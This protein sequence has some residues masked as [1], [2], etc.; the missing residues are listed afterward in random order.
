LESYSL[1]YSV[2]MTPHRLENHCE[3]VSL[4]HYKSQRKEFEVHLICLRLRDFRNYKKL[5][6]EL[7][8]GFHLLTG[9][10][11]QGKTNFLEAIYLLAS[12]KSFR[13]VGGAHMIQHGQS[14][15]F[16]GGS[17]QSTEIHQVQYYWSSRQR[18]LSVDGNPVRHVTEYLGRF[19]M[20]VFCSEDLLLV[21]GASRIRRRYLDF[22]L[23][24]TDR[25][26][27]PLLQRY[28]RTL[29]ARNALLKR[30]GSDPDIL[31]SFTRELITAGEQ[32]VC[33]RRKLAP[34]ISVLARLA[35]RRIS[36][37][38]EELKI[39]YSSSIKED[40]ETELAR[41]AAREKIL[42]YTLIGPHRDE[43]KFFL[44]EH[45]AADFG[46]EG[47]KR[48]I[49]IA[50]KMAQAEYLSGVCD[51]APIL[52]IDDVMGEL[53]E[54]RRAGFLPLLNRVRRAGSQVFMTC[55]E[56]NWPSELSEYMLKWQVNDGHLVEAS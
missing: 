16:V 15:L 7:R 53:D 32:L 18:K 9:N 37:R 42:G 22:L 28:S 49:A 34:R 25:L 33:H 26:Y 17:L 13:G 24:Q 30:P 35:H 50:L 52:L 12:L 11:A 3:S 23:A 46:S 38:A 2:N 47:Q 45:A 48:T 1:S 5:D 39:E 10:N 19:P 40:F 27:L 6:I 54:K 41:T 29:R 55:T 31:N 44:D 43:L 14:G 4:L 36:D 51:T 21:R 8:P 56:D 20:V